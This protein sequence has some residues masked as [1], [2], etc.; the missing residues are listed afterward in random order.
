MENGGSPGKNPDVKEVRRI[1][2]PETTDETGTVP[3]DNLAL[4]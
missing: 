4:I 2:E 1:P 3:Q